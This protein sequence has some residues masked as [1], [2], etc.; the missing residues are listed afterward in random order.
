[1]TEHKL[2]AIALIERIPDEQSAAVLKLLQNVCEL[3]GVDTKLNEH[4][5]ARVEQNIALME[6]VEAL[7]GEDEITDKE[8]TT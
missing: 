1:M 2:A 6:E 4:L 7:I 8:A 3:I 5:I